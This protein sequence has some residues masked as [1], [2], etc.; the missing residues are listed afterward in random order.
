[1]NYSLAFLNFLTMQL[2]LFFLSV[3]VHISSCENVFRFGAVLSADGP[4]ET[5]MEEAKNGY[6]IYIDV[7]NGLNRGRGFFLQGKRGTT[8]FYFKYDLLW[9]DDSN[10]ATLHAERVTELIEEDNV[11]FLGGSRAEFAEEEM[12]MANAGGVL[13]Y[14]CCVAPDAYY[15]NAL[16]TVF[17]ISASNAQYT[18]DYISALFLVGT[19][20]TAFLYDEEDLFTKTTCEEAEAYFQSS[21]NPFGHAEMVM[22][23]T[24]N[25]STLTPDFFSGLAEETKSLGVQ[26][27]IACVRPEEGKDLVNALHEAKYSLKSLFVTEGPTKQD[28]V[29]S[30]KPGFRADAI[31]S[32]DTWH[33]QLQYPD[34]FFGSSRRFAALYRERF[35]KIPSCNGAAAAAVGLTLTQA[36]RNAFKQCDISETEGDVEAL[37]YDRRAIQC[38]DDLGRRGYDRVLAALSLLEMDTFFGHVKFNPYGRNIGTTP[39]T[40]QVF[41][42]RADNGAV[43]REIEAVMPVSFASD[44]P[45][46]P[47]RNHYKEECSPGFYASADEFD[48]CKPCRKGEVSYAMNSAHCD[49]C[50]IGQWMDEKGGSACHEC[51]EGTVTE[52]RG[53]T[54]KMDCRCRPGFFNAAQQ[55]GVECEKCPEGAE[56]PGGTELPIPLFGYW[57]NET[58][59]TYIYE[60]DPAS[61]CEGGPS[62]TCAEGHAGR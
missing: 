39:V 26:A 62:V 35:G 16:P 42:R 15:K 7:V 58:R 12:E 51:P 56:C 33:P 55:M 44:L 17:G 38:D 8:G 49:S 59:R 14:H 27:M 36:I 29:D 52:V 57:A 19:E 31:L 18:N 34:D 20:E 1:M 61:V 25:R 9:R 2:L 41:Q 54:S 11:H 32:A 22:S 48:R 53:A 21:K 24:F 47:A 4:P 50:P 60:C 43:Y 10:D 6:E 23:R 28:W 45:V 13:N 5:N 40:T 37:L 3:L 30:F 46:Y